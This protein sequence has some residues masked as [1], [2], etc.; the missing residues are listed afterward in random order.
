MKKILM[1]LALVLASQMAF[2]QTIDEVFEKVKALPNAQYQEISKEMMAFVLAQMNDEKTKKTMQKV[3]SMSFGMI[4][5]PTEETR[6]A[7]IDIVSSLK[8]RYNK[9]AEEQEEGQ[10]MFVFTDSDDAGK[11]L[12]LMLVVSEGEGCQLIYFKGNVGREDLEAL[13]NMK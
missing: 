9:V 7:F 13:S 3:E 2:C 10:K 1:T 8:N 12:G 4:S 5:S 11:P 6:T